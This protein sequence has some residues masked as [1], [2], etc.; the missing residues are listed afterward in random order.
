LAEAAE[1]FR[2]AF[3]ADFRA[4]N[5]FFLTAKHLA[6]SKTKNLIDFEAMDNANF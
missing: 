5:A 3:T 6:G 1:S 2:I 4:V